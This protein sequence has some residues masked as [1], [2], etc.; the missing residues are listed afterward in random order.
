M[1][2]AARF[3]HLPG[4]GAEACFDGLHPTT[5]RSWLLRLGYYKLHRPKERADG[6]V[7]IA[8][9]TNQIGQEKCLMVVGVRLGQWSAQRRALRLEDLEPMAILPVRQ[10]DQEVVYRQLEQLAS[11][12]GVP[13]AILSDT[14]GDLVKGIE[15]FCVEHPETSGVSDIAHRA[16]RF[17]KRRLE[18]DRR[19]E[20]FVR[21]VSQT[22]FQVQ[23]TELGFLAPPALRT[24]ARYMN[25]EPLIRWAATAWVVL[26][27][28]P[29]PLLRDVSAERLQEKLG[30]LVD[31]REDIAR[32]SEY[33]GLIDEAVAFVRCEGY[34][35]G[36]ADQLDRK[37]QAHQRSEAGAHLRRELVEF[38]AQQSEKARPG[39]RL[40][41]SSEI[42]EST[43]GKLKHLEKDQSRRGF[44]HLVLAFA[45]LTG[46]TTIQTL[47][48]AL[49]Q[50]PLKN[51]RRWC[52]DHL[53]T[54]MHAKRTWLS[55][56]V[57][58]LRGRHAQQNPEEP[59]T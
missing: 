50:V 44:S 19:W 25:L 51:V 23:Q 37:L 57:T 4:A 31:Y 27:E 52:R 14:G 39:E 58:R 49:T 26:D 29:P 16:A 22:K 13:R 17:L 46:K 1:Q 53:G 34:F 11:R 20:L 5:G 56:F 3:A 32:W 12:H 40:P 59:L 35:A 2:T 36:A 54:T 7:W 38:V 41:G 45:A 24:K 33:Q 8:D 47:K 43:F 28:K 30:W 6:W 18:N 48:E 21:E 9:H 15:R 42:I 10:S 55:H